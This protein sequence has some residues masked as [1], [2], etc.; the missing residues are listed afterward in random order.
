MATESP[1][2]LLVNPLRDL[3]L[4]STILDQKSET[5]NLPLGVQ[6]PG[7]T[8]SLPMRLPDASNASIMQVA[9]DTSS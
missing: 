8:S 7:S 6:K 1:E 3:P 5:F 9:P 2:W 4:L